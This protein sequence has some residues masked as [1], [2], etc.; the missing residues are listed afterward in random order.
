MFCIEI[1]ILYEY[2]GGH[3]TSMAEKKS[4]ELHINRAF[5]YIITLLIL[6]LLIPSIVKAD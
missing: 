3:R 1:N 5:S 6:S 2:S 4:F